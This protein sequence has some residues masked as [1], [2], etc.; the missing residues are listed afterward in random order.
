MKTLKLIPF[1]LLLILTSCSTVTVY[2][3]YDK[4]VDF[5]PYK[6]Y[7]YFKPG[8]DKVEISDLD[9]RRILR[10]ID[11]QMQAKGFTKSDNPDLLVNIFTKSREQVDVNQFSA[12]WGYGWGWGWNPY[13]M[14]GG[15]TT[16]ST[17]TEGT[18]YIDL[19][20]AKKKEM[21]WQGEGVGTLTR[22]IDKKDEKI[23]EFVAKILAQYPPVKK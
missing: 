2:S 14:Y 9:K 5:T 18:L 15:Q 10:A 1:L 23:A 4:T 11:D 22:N 8:I 6:T 13:M 21:I 17:S 16:V 7:A 12:G 20:D 19:I 3:D